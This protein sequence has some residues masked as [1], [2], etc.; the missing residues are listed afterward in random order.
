MGSM[1]T[2]K[3]SLGSMSAVSSQNIY[4]NV[5]TRKAIPINKLHGYVHAMQ[6]KKGFE[7]EYKVFNIYIKISNVY[8]TVF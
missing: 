6:K 3:A 4:A 7:K 2:D 1:G 5:P 8:T